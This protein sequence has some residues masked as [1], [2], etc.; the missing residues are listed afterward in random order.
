MSEMIEMFDQISLSDFVTDKTAESH[1][2]VDVAGLN[3]AAARYLPDA[4]RFPNRIMLGTET[5]PRDIDRNW[6]LVRDLSYVLGDFTW[7]GWD[8]LG[9]AGLG[10]TDYTDDPA[11]SSA[12]DPAF[13]WLLAWC[14][15]IDITGHRRPA[16]YYR[17]IVFGLRHEPY[18]AV[19]R[20]E[21]YGKRRFE[22]PWAWSDVV[23]SWTWNV[24][25]GSPVEVEVYSDA[26]EVELLL[27]GERIGRAPAGSGH[28]FRACFDVPYRPGKLTAVAFD[29]GIE[30]SRSTLKTALGVALTAESDRRVIQADHGD[31]AYVS[32]ELRD[33]DG[34]LNTA[35]DAVVE[36]SVAGPGVLQALGSARPSTEERFDAPS[37][38]TFDGRALAVIRP[39]AAGIIAVTVAADGLSPVTLEIESREAVAG[40]VHTTC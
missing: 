8:Y 38:T 28:R 16:S 5:N 19:F 14:G 22:M 32:I 7:T 20:P 24:A 40:H 4:E 34:T 15:D 10:R 17:E 23:S 2:I 13:P 30:R 11:A 25:A 39:L 37:R 29:G 31:L 9:E 12:P 6:Q 27:D 18:I 21:H 35:V 3:Y 26:D 36:V 1:S 33:A